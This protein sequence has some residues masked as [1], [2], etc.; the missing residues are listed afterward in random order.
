MDKSVGQVWE[1]K[2]LITNTRWDA[3]TNKIVLSWQQDRRFCENL[4]ENHYLQP[5]AQDMH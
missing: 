1:G 4:W 5:S 3:R 2:K